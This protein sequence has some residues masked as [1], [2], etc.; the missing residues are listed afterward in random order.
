MKMRRCVSAV[1][2]IIATLSI[3]GAGATDS[4]DAA[5]RETTFLMVEADLRLY[6]CHL[7]E[8]SLHVLQPLQAT[9]GL[10]SPASPGPTSPAILIAEEQVSYNVSLCRREAEESIRARL[11]VAE[12]ELSERSIAQEKLKGFVAAW[13]S[14]MKVIPRTAPRTEELLAQQDNDRRRVMQKQSELEV[15]LFWSLAHARGWVSLGS[16]H[17]DRQP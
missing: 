15:E 14:A 11:Q 9:V 4:F 5:Y 2:L 6:H 10:D 12:Q 13:L 16:A 1:I 3:Y 17:G 7:S 8:L